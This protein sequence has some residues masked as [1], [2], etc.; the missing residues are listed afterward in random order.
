VKV[1]L[2]KKTHT[3]TTKDGCVY[4][5]V[6]KLIDQFVPFFDFEQK[7]FDYSQKHG[8]PV[9]EV[10]A[11]WKNKNIQSTVYGQKIHSVIEESI[12]EKKFIHKEEIYNNILTKVKSYITLKDKV[13]VEEIIHDDAFKIAG[14]SDLIIERQNNFDIIDFKTNKKI[15]FE[16][17]FDDAVLLF[18]LNT[19]PNAEYFKYALQLSLYAYIHEQKTK[20][21]VYRLIVFWFKR[22]NLEDYNC[23]EGT[24]VKLSLP[25]LKEEVKLMLEYGAKK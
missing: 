14:T 4:K 24:W 9:E 1:T 25:Y 17:P 2:D 3:Y 15:K 8:I 16:N 12:K 5:S 6:S 10:R 23:Y 13:L 22:K 20:K 18:P 21:N 11:N 19:L 7:S